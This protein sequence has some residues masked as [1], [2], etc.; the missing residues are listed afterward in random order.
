MIYSLV[1][2][3]H[4]CVFLLWMHCLII[5]LFCVVLGHGFIGA[6]ITWC[7]HC[8]T[9]YETS[10]ST[11]R[12]IF[13]NPNKRKSLAWDHFDKF[14]DEEGKTKVRC[15]YCSKEYMADSKDYKTSNLK[16]HTPICH[17]YLFNELHDGQNPLSKDV[18][19]GNLVPRTFKMLWVEK[20]LLRW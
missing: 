12:D 1:L 10:S 18:E 3:F 14:I 7:C 15:R 19:E 9:N 2:L 16:S 8:K 5:D 11:A 4:I 20:F 6:Y 13:S 17:D